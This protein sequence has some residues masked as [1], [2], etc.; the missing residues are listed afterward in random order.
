MR[1]HVCL[2]CSDLTS[3]PVSG[4]VPIES[5]QNRQLTRAH[6]ASHAAPSASRT[7]RANLE[8]EDTSSRCS[9]RCAESITWK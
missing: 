9:A 6:A 1:S 3:S 2:H 5:G 8:G 7:D 4:A